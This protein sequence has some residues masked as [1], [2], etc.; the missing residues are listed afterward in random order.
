MVAG[1]E[2]CPKRLSPGATLIAILWTSSKSFYLVRKKSIAELEVEMLNGQ[3]LQGPETAAEVNYML[4]ARVRTSTSHV[5]VP[6]FFLHRL[7]FA[8]KRGVFV[9]FI[10]TIATGP[11]G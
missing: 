4:K 5:I 3:K 11:G 7:S 2:R 1:T 8:T 6:T 10:K 9:L